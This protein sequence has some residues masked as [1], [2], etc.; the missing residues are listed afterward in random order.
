MNPSEYGFRYSSAQSKLIH[1]KTFFI[2]KQFIKYFPVDVAEPMR[3]PA[4]VS[5]ETLLERASLND[6]EVEKER[7]IMEAVKNKVDENPW[8][9]RTQWTSMFDRCEMNVLVE[10]YQRPREDAFLRTVWES[11]TR[12]L[13][14]ICMDGVKDCNKRGWEILLY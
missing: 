6:V 7:D 8:E 3:A 2:S 13:K 5:I 10:G 14:G 11:V 1:I 4:E 12:V 9:H